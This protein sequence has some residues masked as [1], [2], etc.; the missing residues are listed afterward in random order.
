MVVLDYWRATCTSAVIMAL[1]LLEAAKR[2]LTGL[3]TRKGSSIAH[4]PSGSGFPMR[5]RLITMRRL[6]V[7]ET[8]HSYG[9]NKDFEPFRLHN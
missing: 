2:P 5:W 3:T 1:R 4:G 8:G 6:V 7:L 9:P